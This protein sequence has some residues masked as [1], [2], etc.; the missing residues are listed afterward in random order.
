VDEADYTVG[1]LLQAN[2]GAR[3]SLRVDGGAAARRRR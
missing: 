3:E 2:Y 1:A